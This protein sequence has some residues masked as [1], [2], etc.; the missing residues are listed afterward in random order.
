MLEPAEKIVI[1]YLVV[2]AGLMVFVNSGLL[3]WTRLVGIQA[4]GIAIVLAMA[5]AERRTRERHS[6]L[7]MRIVGFVRSWYLVA[8]V[9]V[10]YTELRY[11]IPLIHPRDF[12]LQLA[13]L[14]HRLFGVH[15][16][17]WLEHYQWPLLTEILQICYTS[18]YALPIIMGAV[19]WKAHRFEA[20][21][22][23]FYSIVLG[24]LISYIGY[25]AV[26]AIGPRFIPT[27]VLAQTQPLTGVWL[28]APIRTFLD[29]AEGITRDCFPS[30]HTEITLL[31]L[32]YAYQ[33][34]KRMFWIMLPVGLAIIYSTVYLRYHYVIDVIAGAAVAALVIVIAR[35]LYRWLGGER[36]P[37]D[38]DMA[39]G[40]LAEHA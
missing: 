22:F 25:I 38:D 12:D 29:H 9:P 33:L 19:L 13:A 37:H 1:A 3:T 39:R 30:G 34:H 32:Y 26:P 14:D 7:G 17:V 28:F 10:I 15:P 2:L 18:Y 31:M 21:R 16:T 36:S 20:F 23:F 4:A 24:F 11:L 27:I 6:A 8:V 35:P 40:S 5:Y